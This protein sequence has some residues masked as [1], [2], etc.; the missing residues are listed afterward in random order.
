MLF[1]KGKIN[2]FFTGEEFCAGSA[3]REGRDCDEDVQ[4]D[5]GRLV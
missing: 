2:S 4:L 5:R 1:V 3:K